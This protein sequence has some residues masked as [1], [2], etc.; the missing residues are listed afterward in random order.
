MASSAYSMC[1]I[2]GPPFGNCMPF[3]SDCCCALLIDVLRPSIARMNKNDD[4]ES[5][6]L[7]PLVI[8]NSWVGTPLTSIEAF[9]D[10]S[11]PILNVYPSGPGALSPPQFHTACFISSIMN[12]MFAINSIVYA[13][14]ECQNHHELG[15]A[16]AVGMLWAS[17]DRRKQSKVKTAGGLIYN[18]GL[19][20]E[21]QKNIFSYE[22]PRKEKDKNAIAPILVFP[23]RTELTLKGPHK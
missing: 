7:T 9:D 12:G 14:L 22:M 18:K 20:M 5:P 11:Q 3:T 10:D 21:N 8:E 1:V 16:S 15:R 4:N 13:W 6:C 2:Q 19:R 17:L 23:K